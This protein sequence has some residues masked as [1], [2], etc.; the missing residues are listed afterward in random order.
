MTASATQSTIA[1]E[2][3][4]ELKKE[5]LELKTE[6][7]GLKAYILKQEKAKKAKE[8]RRSKAG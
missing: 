3:F 5:F 8:K 2:M 6:V 4:E 7:L 1:I